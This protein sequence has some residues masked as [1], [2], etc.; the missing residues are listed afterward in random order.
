MI[1]YY[2]ISKFGYCLND[3]KPP[4]I[5]QSAKYYTIGI[6]TYYNR[7]IIVRCDGLT[8]MGKKLWIVDYFTLKPCSSVT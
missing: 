6:S 5:D 3:Q 1:E 4:I 2:T 8:Y 7:P